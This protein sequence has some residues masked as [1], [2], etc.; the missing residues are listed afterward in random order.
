MIP[1]WLLHR[2]LGPYRRDF[3]RALNSPEQSQTLCLKSLLRDASQ[4]RYGQ[5]L[6]LRP[7][8]SYED[9]ASKVP[10]VTYEDLW[11]WIQ[12]Q[13]IAKS[14]VLTPGAT[15]YYEPTSGSSGR[16]KWIPYNRALL[17]SFDRM[18]K[19][20]AADVLS[21]LDSLKSGR[22]YFSVTP[23]PENKQEE[24]LSLADDASYVQGM[25]QA[26]LRSRAAVSSELKLLRQS[27]A[28]F[29]ALSCSLLACEDL[30]LVSIW[31][32]SFFL[33]L[34]QYIE[35]NRSRLLDLV[36]KG[37]LDRENRSFR[38]KKPTL[39]R[40]RLLRE[41]STWPEFWPRLRFISC[42]DAAR[43]GMS[44]GRLRELF[45]NVWVQGKG[46]LATEAPLTVPIQSL[47]GAFPLVNE[48]FFEFIAP[49]GCILRL[50]ELKPGDSYEVLISQRGGF[51]RYRLGDRVQVDA[52]PLASPCLSFVE[53]SGQV[54]DLT[55]EKLQ[56]SALREA[57]ES[58][59]AQLSDFYLALP[60]LGRDGQ[61]QYTIVTDS[62]QGPVASQIEEELLKLHHYA[63]ARKLR[64]LAPLRV[65]SDPRAKHLYLI[66][67]REQGMK[68]GD[69]KETL[70]IR[71]LDFASALLKTLGI[72][73]IVN[74]SLKPSESAKTKTSAN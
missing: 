29:E 72:P 54:S 37:G 25:M 36:V 64:Q 18:F 2:Y 58:A 69:M 7:G 32:P 31:N 53:R 14:S 21:E 11:P 67:R 42:W 40:Q 48:V 52:S 27:E 5:S 45:P 28:F 51:L 12:Q 33:Q 39:Q 8:D 34:L 71:D 22:F 17:Q 35:Q 66:L 70:L 73:S 62:M 68:L 43:A 4:T 60:Q 38:W 57:L 30:E 74:A 61:G 23:V 6:N 13:W 1:N 65:V 63:L 50:H 16:K 26:L 41:A 10:P 55:G 19:I 59:G 46:L 15:R 24:E 20:W 47:G 49:N 9:F 44:A 56:E 3:L